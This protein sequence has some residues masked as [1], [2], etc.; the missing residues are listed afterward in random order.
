MANNS[1]YCA[2]PGC[3]HPADGYLPAYNNGVADEQTRVAPALDALRRI[4]G[5]PLDPRPDGTFNYSR[6]A[7]IDIA[8]RGLA[9]IGE[10]DDACR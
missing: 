10:G 9:E 8:Q 1:G 7:L 5:M 4:A 3:R 6:G 2:E